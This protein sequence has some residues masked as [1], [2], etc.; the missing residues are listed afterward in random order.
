MSTEIVDLS[1]VKADC[2]SKNE[3][4]SDQSTELESEQGLSDCEDPASTAP[5][6]AAVEGALLVFDWDDTILPTS[7]LEKQG[8]LLDMEAILSEERLSQLQ[9]LADSAAEMLEAAIQQGRVVVITNAAEGWVQ[10]SCLHFLPSLAPILKRLPI[11]SARSAFES[12]LLRCPTEW[13]SRAFEREVQKFTQLE[14]TIQTIVSLGDAV[15]E[16]QACMRAAHGVPHC[17]AKMLKFADHPS[18]EQLIEEHQLVAGTLG[19]VV[20]YEEDLDINVETSI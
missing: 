1:T 7:W 16:H 4:E 15:H 14:G 13:K 8:V 9:V 10:Y 12:S 11:M 5:S 6:S 19:D 18:I 2:C 3:G 20:Q 17:S